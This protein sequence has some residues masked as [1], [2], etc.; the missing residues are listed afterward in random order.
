MW[1]QGVYGKSLYLNF[2]VPGTCLK[3]LKSY[4]EIKVD[5]WRKIHHANTNQQ[6]AELAVVIS[7]QVLLKQG[8][9]G[10]I[11]GHFIKREVSVI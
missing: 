3:K 7:D 9:L 8:K 5:W 10:E 4:E 1:E 11:K 2:S 6:K